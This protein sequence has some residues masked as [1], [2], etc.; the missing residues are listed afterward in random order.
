[1]RYT[2]EGFSQAEAIK[3]RCTEIVKRKNQRT[4]EYEEKE[5]TVTLD[6]N[7]LL[8]LRWFVDF[9]PNM[10][11]VEISGCQYA[12]VSYKDLIKD[13]PLLGFKK[14]MLAL[15]L[16]KLVNFGILTHKT[17]KKDGT[18]SYY[19]FGPNYGRLVDDDHSDEN[20][21]GA[22]NIKDP[23]PKKLDTPTQKISDQIDSSTKD[24]STKEQSIGQKP[25]KSGFK[26]PTREE[27]RA[28]VKEKGYHFDPDHFFDYYE[29]SD[30][31]L[32]GGKKITRWKQC[33]VTWERNA[34]NDAADNQHQSKLDLSEYS[35][36]K[37]GS[38]RIDNRTNKKEVYKGNGVWEE[39]VSNYVP[40]EGDED[41]EL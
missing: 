33:C 31:H 6:C 37:V 10:I 39:Y 7:D 40:Q 15:R 2:I 17:V 22:Q 23:L 4:G 20:D 1:M 27:V 16:K 29:A 35:E 5:T 28:Y 11:K 14:G 9:Y 21:G 36:P 8:I 13:M 26:A 34:S 18:F 19:G 41:I 32:Q 25:K 30:W 38:M 3:F 12:W 24:S